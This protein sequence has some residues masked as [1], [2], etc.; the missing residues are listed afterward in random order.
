MRLKPI[1]A[2]LALAAVC[3]ATL[4][5]PARAA[6]QAA[7]QA[8]AQ[9]NTPANSK[10]SAPDAQKIFLDTDIGD[11]IDDAYALG[12]LLASPNVQITGISSAWGDT[13]LRSRELDRLLCLTGRDAIPV[14]TGVVKT[15]PGAGA[16]SQRAWASHGPSRPHPQAVDLL[17]QTI[18][19]YPGQVTLV[20]LGPMTNLGA[21][22]DRDPATF[23]KLRRIVLMGGSV[24]HG[25]DDDH[26]L[27]PATAPQ[28]EYNI[29]MDPEAAGKVF[30]SGVPLVVLPL[31]STQIPLD[32]T[33]RAALAG[34]STP[35]TDALQVLTNE[36]ATVNHY[37]NPTLYDVVAAAAALDANSCPTTPLH[38]E[39][40]A[41]GNTRS[42]PGTPNAEACLAPHADA[43]FAL[44]MPRLLEQHLAGTGACYVA[45]P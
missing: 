20:S 13:A 5:A 38:L 36:W 35:L 8:A 37:P 22:V 28:P 24:N 17:L 15:R 33:R 25:Y 1:S 7:V 29:A 21:A 16:F 12:L 39:V 40:D 26:P 45:K 44:L 19:R 2:A 34:V 3:A 6:V 32:A 10:P 23:R 9:A 4:P 31:D 43:F 14:G 30:R 41:A 42:T 18:R 27:A 11:D